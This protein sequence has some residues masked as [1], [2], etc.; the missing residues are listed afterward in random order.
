MT[1]LIYGYNITECKKNEIGDEK[2][3]VTQKINSQLE[4]EITKYSQNTQAIMQPLFNFFFISLIVSISCFA[5]FAVINLF[6]KEDVVS[7]IDTIRILKVFMYIFLAIG[8]VSIIISGIMF[9]I[10]YKKSKSEEVVGLVEKT[11]GLLNQALH[12]LSVPESA[13]N[14]DII[15][16]KYKNVNGKNRLKKYDNINLIIWRD[17]DKINITNSKETVSILISNIKDVVEIKKKMKFE[18]WNKEEKPKKGIYKQYK[19]SSKNDLSFKISKFYKIL[20]ETNDDQYELYLPNYEIDVFLRLS[21]LR[22]SDFKKE[23]LL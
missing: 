20:I 10:I 6:A 19:I 7:S 4:E 11:N 12:E 14:M 22:L 17:I 16:F 9:F 8:I 3:L 1:K 18:M 21:N 15:S 13:T 23:I 2:P 5:I